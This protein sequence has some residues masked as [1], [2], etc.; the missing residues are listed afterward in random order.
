MQKTP[1][2]IE[3]SLRYIPPV[4]A[5]TS[6]QLSEQDRPFKKKTSRGWRRHDIFAIV[7][8]HRTIRPSEAEIARQ[9]LLNA[10]EILKTHFE[11]SPQTYLTSDEVA[12]WRDNLLNAAHVWLS[13]NGIAHQLIIFKERSLGGLSPPRETARLL[14]LAPTT[15]STN[16]RR[17][18][19]EVALTFDPYRLTDDF[20]QFNEMVRAKTARA[21]RYLAHA[22]TAC[23]VA[24]NELPKM[25][26]IWRG[27]P[28]MW[29]EPNGTRWARF[30]VSS[31]QIDLRSFT[32]Q[33]VEIDFLMRVMS[34]QACRFGFSATPSAFIYCGPAEDAFAV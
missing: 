17:L 6:I 15:G 18:S 24:L 30:Q 31:P 4:T 21:L 20:R 13:F 8:H 25:R 3:A 5:L 29:S 23:N 34:D 11:G 22:R 2:E 7:P 12:L 10:N 33:L 9:F 28:F 14:Y 16:L 19:R 26:S 32:T 1:L 27:A